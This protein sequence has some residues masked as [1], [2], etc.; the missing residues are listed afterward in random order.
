MKYIWDPQKATANK[1]KH[2]IDFADIVAI[3][4]D[5]VALWQE[6]MREYS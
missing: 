4:E 1:I 2:G 6:D 3:F 5:D